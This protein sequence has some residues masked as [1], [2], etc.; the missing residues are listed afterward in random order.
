M[1]ASISY[2]GRVR[3]LF[4]IGCMPPGPIIGDDMGGGWKRRQGCDVMCVMLIFLGADV[5]G[6]DWISGS[7][8]ATR[9]GGVVHQGNGKQRKAVGLDTLMC[10]CRV[11]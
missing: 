6:H 1:F 10:E 8:R 7:K 2:D 11:C 5:A 3:T 9:S 4:P